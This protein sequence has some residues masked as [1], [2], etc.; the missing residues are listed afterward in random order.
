MKADAVSQAL[1]S[2]PLVPAPPIYSTLLSDGRNQILD[3]EIS[4]E[5]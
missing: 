3:Q 5:Q 2:A 4:R 1:A